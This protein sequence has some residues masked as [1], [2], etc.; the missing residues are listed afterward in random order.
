MVEYTLVKIEDIKEISDFIARLNK[1]GENHLSKLDNMRIVELFT[2][3]Y[4][5]SMEKYLFKNTAKV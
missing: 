5:D 1:N 4:E 3:E 2:D